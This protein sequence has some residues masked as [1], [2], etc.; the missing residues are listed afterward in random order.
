MS[1][2]SSS[3]ST[4]SCTRT[5]LTKPIS[6]YTLSLLQART[7]TQTG[8]SFH[9]SLFSCVFQIPKQKS[10]ECRYLFGE[11]YRVRV[12]TYFKK[13]YK[14]LE[15]VH[16]Y[17]NINPTCVTSSARWMTRPRLSQTTWSPPTA[18]IRRRTRRFELRQQLI[19]QHGTLCSPGLN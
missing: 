7:H 1:S 5:K 11:S 14:V 2:S 12:I 18:W 19:R 10:E 6:A 17:S 15:N 3:S 16:K 4:S 8:M 9:E 13:K